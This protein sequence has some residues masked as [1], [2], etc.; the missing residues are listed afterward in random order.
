MIFLDIETNLKHDTIWL[1]VT[2]HNTTGEVRHWREADSL[3]QYLDGEQVVGHNIIGFDAPVLKKV[4]GVGIPDNKLV[5]TLVMSRLYKPDIDIVIPEQGKA[6]SPHSLEAWGYRL[7]SHKIGFTAFD[8]GYTESMAIYCEQD[9]L[10]LEKLY[11]HLTTVMVKEGFSLQSIQLEHEVAII[12]RGMEDNGFMLDMPKAMALHAILSGRMSDIEEEMQKVFP[13]IVEQR[14]SEKTGKQL[15]DKV[16]IFNPGSRQQIGDRLIKL[17]WKPTKMTP[18]GQPIVDEDTLKGV[19]FPEGQ[20]IAEYL[21]IQK[22]VAQISSWLELVGDDGRVHGRVTTNGAVTGR[23]THSSPNMAQVPAV[24][25]P[26]GAECREMWR[27]PVGY[28]Q[29]GVDLSGIELRCMSH[30]LQD[31]GWQHELLNGDVHWK[32]AQSFGLVPEGT[33]KDDNNHEHKKARNLSKTLVY[34]ASY[35]AGAAKIGSIVG[36]NSS[37]G[38]KLL[39]NFINNTPGLAALKKKISKF[40]SKGHLPGLDGRRVWVRSEHAA[41]NTLLQSAGAIIA[42]QWLVESTKMLQE[43]GIDAKLLA[44]V[45]DETQWEVREDQAEEAAK[46][47]E[48]AATKA[49]EALAFRC[50]VNA[51]GKVGDNWKQ[52][53]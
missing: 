45:H 25:S 44:F 47:I 51:E 48:Q 19:V 36:A 40:M 4:W 6:P 43:K 53:H 52:T 20:I 22:R 34:A 13:P 12:C 49:G 3:Q 46:L 27:V 16:T 17:G 8:G 1:C 28:K 18:T 39:D 23:A 2:K 9:V 31:A 41:L 33:I 29:V 21:M 35:G 5:D 32:N 30:Y 11:N 24:G 7:G 10:L 26:F 38:K 50:P 37:K 15:K 42:K 14:I